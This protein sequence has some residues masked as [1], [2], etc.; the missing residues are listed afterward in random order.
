MTRSEGEGQ[1]DWYISPFLWRRAQ[2]RRGP[3]I[4]MADVR[5]G[6]W[7]L[8]PRGVLG[9]PP[10]KPLWKMQLALRA[11]LRVPIGSMRSGPLRCRQYQ[12]TSA[13]LR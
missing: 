11:S 5:Q 1:P 12:R 13:A 2:Y 7:R 3:P 8:S 4:T 9:A 10:R 6:P